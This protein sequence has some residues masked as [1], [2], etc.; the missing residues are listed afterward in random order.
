VRRGALMLLRVQ[1]GGTELASRSRNVSFAEGLIQDHSREKGES[2]E[3]LGGSSR[4]T[5]IFQQINETYRGENRKEG[6]FN[7]S[8]L[9]L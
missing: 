9:Q 5:E 4:Q 6:T 2:A 7:G 3:K 1:T 8:S